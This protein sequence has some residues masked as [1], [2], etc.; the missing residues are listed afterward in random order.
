MEAVEIRSSGG[1]SRTARQVYIRPAKECDNR[2]RRC[3][4]DRAEAVVKH[5]YTPMVYYKVQ[6]KII[7][8]NSEKHALSEYWLI[9]DKKEIGTVFPVE[10]IIL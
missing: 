8:S 6:G 9:C 5:W 1:Y 10:E 4:A 7:G 3:K 2:S